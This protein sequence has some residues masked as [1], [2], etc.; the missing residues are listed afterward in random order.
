MSEQKTSGLFPP[1][2]HGISGDERR[3]AVSA[4]DFGLKRQNPLKRSDASQDLFNFM[5]S[6]FEF[7]L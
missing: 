1:Q 3:L 2:V 7:W 6:D 5:V 4:S